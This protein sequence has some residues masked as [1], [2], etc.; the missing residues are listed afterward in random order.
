MR[1]DAHRAA[2]AAAQR[3]RFERPEERAKI[4]RARRIIWSP[5]MDR[6]LAEHMQAGGWLYEAAERIGV[7]VTAARRRCLE[8]GIPVPLH[9]FNGG[10]PDVDRTRRIVALREQG[11]PVSVIAARFGLS[12][13]AVYSRL[14]WWPR[15]LAKMSAIAAATGGERP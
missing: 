3:R 1:T 2:I 4:A 7:D 5:E 6:V 8:M 12:P 14:A 13:G 10:R 15:V 11:M 9:R